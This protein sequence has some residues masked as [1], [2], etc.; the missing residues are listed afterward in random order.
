MEVNNEKFVIERSSDGKEFVAVAIVEGNGNSTSRLSYGALDEQPLSGISYY[1]LKQVD[2]DGTTAYSDIEVIRNMSDNA[3]IS[4][5]P[6]P[7]RNESKIAL[8]LHEDEKMEVVVTDI[9]GQYVWRANL[10]LEKGINII[11]IDLSD[12]PDGFYT[13]QFLSD[14]N[15]VRSLQLI[16]Q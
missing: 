6:N 8:R 10:S 14:N 12:Q 13:V 11:P 5:Y 3:T 15:A 2:F 16:K 7:T 4:A 1:R 9:V